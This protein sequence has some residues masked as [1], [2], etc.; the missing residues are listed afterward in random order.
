MI[1]LLLNQAFRGWIV[2][3]TAAGMP[4][5]FLGSFDAVC[6]VG[7]VSGEASA[8]NLQDMVEVNIKKKSKEQKND[9]RSK[10]QEIE[11]D[12]KRVIASAKSII[13]KKISP[14]F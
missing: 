8:K 12:E 10:L 14:A 6:R 13:I 2:A 4:A 3:G 9:L 11:A 1:F 5:G 7:R